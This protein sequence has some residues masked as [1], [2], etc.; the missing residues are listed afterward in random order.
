MTGF[1]LA[2]IGEYMKPLFMFV[3]IICIS[4]NSIAADSKLL[5]DIIECESS[6]RHDAVGDDGVSNGIAQF[7]KETFY[8]FAR[9][10]K[11]K[12]MI[13]KNPIHQ[14]RLMNWAIDHGYGNRW[15]CF[16][17]L[18]VMDSIKEK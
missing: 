6:G 1:E 13:Y 14:L 8:E 4:T 5:I 15:T 17:K 3:A 10:A 2:L 7:R 11:M 12:G 16:R 9:Q 18:T